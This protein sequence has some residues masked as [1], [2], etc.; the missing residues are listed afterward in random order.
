MI[1]LREYRI[2]DLPMVERLME[3][4][5]KYIISVDT[6][7]RL[8]F[9]EGYGKTKV[10]EMIDQSKKENGTVYVA[11]DEEKIIGFGAC[12]IGHQTKIE[13]MEN[14]PTVYGSITELYV[15]STYR[16][17]QVG[18][19][20]LEKIEEYLKEKGCTRMY[21]EVFGPN[22]NAQSFYKKKGYQIRDVMMAKNI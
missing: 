14:V 9:T 22:T 21:I 18:K 19:M 20:L 6:E 12:T 10:E 16:R 8:I 2:E 3:D 4:F 5:Q 13:K 15:D 7:N 11:C 17:K 1:T